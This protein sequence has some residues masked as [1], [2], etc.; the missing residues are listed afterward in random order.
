MNEEILLVAGFIS[1]PIFLCNVVGNS[2]VVTVVQMNKKMQCPNTYL[3]SCLAL[4]DF[5]FGFI[6]ETNIYLSATA[7]NSRLFTTYTFYTLLSILTL[8]L[9]AIER[10]LAIL[11]PFFYKARVTK[12]LVKKLLLMIVA[13]S[14]LVTAPSYYIFGNGNY[15]VEFCVNSTLDET[16]AMGYLASLLV[17]SIT[18]PGIVMILCYSRIVQHVWFSNEA[19]KATSKALLRSRWKLTKLFM[20]ATVIFIVSWSPS[21]GRLSASSFRCSDR[22]VIYEVISILLALL[23]SMAN[24]ILY[25]FRC[26]GFR[27][28]VKELFADNKCCKRNRF[29][30][31]ETV[32]NSTKGRRSRDDQATQNVILLRVFA[33]HSEL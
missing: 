5:I 21:F 29:C 25:S 20:V 9:L 2:L 14:A 3:L 7:S 19:D 31:S 6:A 24:P 27:Q 4:S 28:A 10:Y 1:L 18:I 15:K 23:G 17:L 33:R 13:F 12:S 22:F 32:L 11:K 30:L 26:P 16:A 8:T